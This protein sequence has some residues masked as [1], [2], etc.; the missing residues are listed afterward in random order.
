MLKFAMRDPGLPVVLSSWALAAALLLGSPFLYHAAFPGAHFWTWFVVSV[1]GSLLILGALGACYLI[2]DWI[3]GRAKKEDPRKSEPNAGLCSL[4]AV[5]GKIRW[6]R[7]EPGGP[8][9]GK[10]L[11]LNI[12]NKSQG[13]LANA[14]LRLERVEK[15][16]PES[17]TWFPPEWFSPLFLVV[18]LND[19]G[20]DKTTITA[21]ETR[22]WDLVCYESEGDTHA[23]ILA[24]QP[25]LRTP[26]RIRFGTWRFLC[27]FAA[28]NC[29]TCD[30]EATIE[31]NST[32]EVPGRILNFEGL[33]TRPVAA[34]D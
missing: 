13:D 18:S 20:G 12:E 22:T 21:G 7:G 8:I 11:V 30:I 17:N 27:R 26:N 34:T 19:G 31:W 2:W 23:K 25:E 6:D 15:W 10:Y 32:D 24:A 29:G 33:A 14:R 5:E 16:L 1:G 28:D 4:I 3:G 9:R